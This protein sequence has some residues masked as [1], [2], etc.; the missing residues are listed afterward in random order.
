MS[1]DG[2]T[3]EPA[4]E[5][6]PSFVSVDGAAKRTSLHQYKFVEEVQ[7]C[8]PSNAARE[9]DY[10]TT[11]LAF[12]SRV[13]TNQGGWGNAESKHITESSVASTNILSAH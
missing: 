8:I 6:M 5:K 10:G 2:T 13:A 1:A 11:H 3:K 4:Y 7:R 9:D 12:V